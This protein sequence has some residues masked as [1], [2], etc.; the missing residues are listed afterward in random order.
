MIPEC[1][2]D[3][4]VAYKWFDRGEPAGEKALALLL[5][6]RDES[7]RLVA[8]SILRFEVANGLRYA[9]LSSD[10][11]LGVVAD[12]SDFQ[13]EMVDPDDAT[14][15]HACALAI[16]HGLSVYDASFLALAIA[17]ACPFVTADRKAFV[18]IPASVCEVR[19]LA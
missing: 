3:S 10:D 2:V 15:G 16:E 7:I 5:A 1:V 8:P 4:S 14:L 17:R 11:L 13:V 18:R 9:G 12:L 6:H 19:L